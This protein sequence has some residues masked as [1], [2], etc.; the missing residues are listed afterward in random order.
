MRRLLLI[1]VAVVALALPAAAEASVTITVLCNGVANSCSTG[2]Y[3]TTVTVSFSVSGDNLK[4]VNCPDTTVSVDTSGVDASCVVTLSDNSITGKA[5]TIK[6]DATPPTVDAFAPARAAD[7]G[8]WYNHAV[9]VAA[10]GSDATSGIA[11]CTSAAY[12]G[13][14]ASAASVS[15]TCTDNAGNVSAAKTLTLAY[16]A[17]PPSVAAA[18]ARGP[19]ANGWYNHA[20]AVAFQGTDATSGVDSCTSGSYAGPDS[21]SAAVAGTCKDKA[22]NT[23]TASLPVQYDATP[24]QVTGAKPSRDPDRNGWYNHALTIAYAGTDAG[25]GIAACDQVTYSKPDDPTAAVSCR[26]H[27]NAG[28]ASAPAPFAFKF[29]SKAPSVTKLTTTSTG[30]A[31]AL[32]WDVSSDVAVL[33]IDRDRAGAPPVTVY[34]GKRITTFTDKKIQD[35]AR[36]TYLIT[37]YDQAGNAAVVKALGTPASALLAPRA[38]A[39]IRSG[40]TL[41]WRAAKNADYYNVQLWLNGKKLL[42]TWPA[43]TSLRLPRLRHGRYLWLVW[44]GLGARSAHRYGPLLGR[45]TFVVT[46]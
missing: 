16:D 11:S 6:R 43:G 18:P 46:G 2:W 40:T 4:L 31:V 17:T 28:N 33:K 27:D 38:S 14:D 39:H 44:P 8:S 13:P 22:G 30:S 24:P 23:G 5:V 9:A 25:S 26:C 3:R 36:Y 32:A 41:R 34:D 45:S 12:S 19:D 10:T 35:G 15:G 7:S 1:G 42:S 21:G 29:D 37:A 20:L